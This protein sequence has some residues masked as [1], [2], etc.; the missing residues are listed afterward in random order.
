MISKSQ[1]SK[2]SLSEKGNIV[3]IEGKH[4][5]YRS[6]YNHTV[7]LFLYNEYYIEV[8]YQPNDNKIDRIELL[9]NINMLNIYINNMLKI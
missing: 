6:Y 8:W 5:A 3:F 1:F 4:L 9:T 7:T 2:L